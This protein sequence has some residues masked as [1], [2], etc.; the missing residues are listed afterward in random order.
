MA[1]LM[2]AGCGILISVSRLPGGN[3]VARENPDKWATSHQTCGHCRIPYCDKCV[4]KRGGLFRGAKC[5]C[6]GSIAAKYNLM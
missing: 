1:V 4:K 6:G 2:C 5:D 3:P